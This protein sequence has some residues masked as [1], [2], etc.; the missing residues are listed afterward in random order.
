MTEDEDE[1]EEEEGLYS[2]SRSHASRV[3]RLALSE[4]NLSEKNYL[5]H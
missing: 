3:T 1:E 4:K 5:T 2:R